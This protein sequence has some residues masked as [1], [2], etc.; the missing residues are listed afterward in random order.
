ML[1][2]DLAVWDEVP[3]ERHRGI[4]AHI[5]AEHGIQVSR[6]SVEQM[7]ELAAIV[8]KAPTLLDVDRNAILQ[9]LAKL[10]E[11]RAQGLSEG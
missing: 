8:R 4:L 6:A 2:R 3:F 10:R 5:G 1:L 11:I 7:D 9:D